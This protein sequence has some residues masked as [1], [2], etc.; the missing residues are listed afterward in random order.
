MLILVTMPICVNIFTPKP[1]WMNVNTADATAIKWEWA[2]FSS[3]FILFSST[4]HLS[5]LY[6]INKANIWSRLFSSQIYF[7]RTFTAFYWDL[8]ISRVAYLRIEQKLNQS[9]L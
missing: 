9:T 8:V 2:F 4:Y 3:F 7:G 1:I 6:E 5:C